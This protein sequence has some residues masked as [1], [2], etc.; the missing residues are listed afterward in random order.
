MAAPQLKTLCETI[1]ALPLQDRL[2]LVEMVMKDAQDSVPAAGEPRP[3]GMDRGKIRIADDFD[4]P[5]PEEVQQGFDG[6]A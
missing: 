5:L 1:R 6:D 3:L 2:R 4:A